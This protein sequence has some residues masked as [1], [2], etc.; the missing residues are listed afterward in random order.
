MADPSAE[1]ISRAGSRLDR[2]GWTALGY[3]PF[4]WFLAA[5]LASTS[6]NFVYYAALGW[7]VLEVTGSPAA[8]GF[9]FTAA[10]LPILFLTPHAGVLTDRL[11]A[12]RMLSLS[13]MGM[14]GVTIVQAVVAEGGA[15]PYA[16]VVV[17]ALALG[18][19]QTVGAPSSVAIVSELVAPPAVSSA[20]ALNFLHMNVSRIV[21]GLLGGVLLATTTASIAFAAAGVLTILAVAIM[22]RL[23]TVDAPAAVERP[24]GALLGPLVEAFRYATRHRTLGVLITLSIAPGAIGLSYIFML[25]V[26]AEELGI[27]AGGLGV[28]MAASGIGGLVAGLSLETIQRRI[29]HGRALFGGMVGAAVGL[30]SF[31]LA[32]SVPL[33]IAALTIVGASFLTFAAATVTL[34]QALAPPRLRG[35]LVSLFATLYWGMMPV[36][37]LVVGLV[38][39]VTTAR[40]AVALCGLGLAIAGGVAFLVRPQ[41]ATLAVGRDGLTLSGNLEGSGVVPPVTGETRI[42]D[43]GQGLAGNRVELATAGHERE[44]L[45]QIDRQADA[46]AG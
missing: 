31:G 44:P 12:R 20:T 13:L 34:T 1:G 5:M 39:E 11:G 6:A 22:T 28:L 35:R 42:A 29:G 10:G 24:R 25:P 8:V 4:R 21:G 41:I 38:A 33:A 2:V 23:R 17:L 14:A 37:A 9:A 32:P 43:V 3:A 19:A 7:Y 45:P 27:G 30:S 36:G 40:S 26:A 15:P 16:V 18:I 46:E